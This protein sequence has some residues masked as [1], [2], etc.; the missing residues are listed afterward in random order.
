MHIKYSI[1]AISAAALLAGCSVGNILTPYKLQIPQGNEIS[2]DQVAQLK[3]GMTRAQ[4]RFVLGTP[5]LTDA[6]HGNRWDYV[7]TEAK[8]GKLE[9]KRTFIVEFDGDKAVSWHGDSMP[10]TKLIKLGSDA[11]APIALDDPTA[12]AVATSATPITQ[13]ASET[14]SAPAAK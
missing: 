12:A 9:S 14:A 7:F 1:I 10:A 4:V 3:P 11:S 8:G 6:F 2:A 5:L 13:V